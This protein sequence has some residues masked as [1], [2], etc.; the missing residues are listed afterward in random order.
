MKN[1]YKASSRGYIEALDGIKR[2]TLVFGEHTILVE[3]KVAAGKKI[4][5]NS[6]SE[7]QTGYLV[8]GHI[9]L[10]LDGKKYDMKP[11]NAWAIPRGIPHSVQIL[12]DS[13]VV[14]IFSPIRRD[15]LP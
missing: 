10:Y 3:F 9:L 14:E 1:I 7:E 13:V 12:E 15:Y 2:K 8:S 5:L 11:G 6:H 4:A